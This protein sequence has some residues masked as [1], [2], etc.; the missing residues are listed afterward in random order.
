MSTKVASRARKIAV[1]LKPKTKAHGTFE[2]KTV[3]MVFDDSTY[4]GKFV[5]RIT[6]RQLNGLK[7]IESNLQD[8]EPTNYAWS[9]TDFGPQMKI[10]S[11]IPMEKG[12]YDLVLKITQWQMGA[13]SGI[14][15]KVVTAT[16]V[17]DVPEEV[18]P[19]TLK[20]FGCLI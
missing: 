4:K 13:T 7:D 8:G 15:Y 17:E 20:S 9:V 10:N 2:I 1:P 6:E 16:R 3:R 5:F 11:D 12:T 14:S 18:R 19:I